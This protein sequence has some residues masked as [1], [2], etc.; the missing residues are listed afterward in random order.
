[1][2]EK[3]A[4]QDAAQLSHQLAI[5]LLRIQHGTPFQLFLCVVA[6]TGIFAVNDCCFCCLFYCCFFFLKNL[7]NGKAMLILLIALSRDEKP[8]VGLAISYGMERSFIFSFVFVFVCYLV[9][10]L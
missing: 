3:K 5:V 8:W 9:S 4:K 2:D 10:V 7:D 1:M 6:E